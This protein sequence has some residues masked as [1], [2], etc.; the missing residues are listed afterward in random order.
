MLLLPLTLEAFVVLCA[1][2]PSVSKMLE[3]LNA[4]GT[5]HALGMT[6]LCHRIEKTHFKADE[7]F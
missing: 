6:V 3:A 7:A 2:L 5:L 4:L 1:F